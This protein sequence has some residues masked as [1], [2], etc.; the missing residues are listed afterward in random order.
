MDEDPLSDTTREEW[1]EPSIREEEL[2]AN[3]P[4]H[5]AP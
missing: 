4:P 2:L 5:H 1:D 3:V